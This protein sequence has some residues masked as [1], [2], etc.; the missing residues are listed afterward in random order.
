MSEKKEE[1]VVPTKEELLGEVTEAEE[2]EG[3]PDELEHDPSEIEQKAMDMGWNPDGVEGKEN[4]SPEEFVGRQKLYDDIRSLKKQNKRQ[5]SDIENITKYQDRI[6]SDERK[7]VLEELRQ[8]KIQALKDEDYNKVADVD[9]KIADERSSQAADVKDTPDESTEFKEWLPDNK[10]YNSDVDLKVEA[11]YL[12][13]KFWKANPEKTLEE[14]FEYVG[15]TVRKMNPDKFDN[16]NRNKPN[17]VEASGNRPQK[18]SS[19]PK[20]KASDMSS[21]EQGIMRTIIR[22]TKG[23][24]EESYLKEYLESA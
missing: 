17:A 2:L 12:G 18:R 4:L 9:D 16:D 23:M 8:E 1:V 3:T 7:N 6:K 19:K 14:V 22:T 5:A 10:W 15:K 21:E 24:T 13:E 20:Y 11:D